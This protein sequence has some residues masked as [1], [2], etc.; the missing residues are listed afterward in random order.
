[1]STYQLVDEPARNAVIKVVGVGGG[2]G[3]AVSFMQ[4]TGI[5]GV[6]LVAVNTDLQALRA[7]GVRTTVQIGASLTRGLGAGSDPE[8][9]RQA[10]L[11][12]RDRLEEVV[13]GADMVFVTAG[14][15]GGTGTGA[16]AV[17]AQLAREA[18]ALVV[19]VVTR[20]FQLE[21][22]RRLEAAD[23][24]LEVLAQHCDSLIVVPNEKLFSVLGPDCTLD[25]AFETANGVLVGAVRGIADLIT[26]PGRM[27]LDFADVR[28]VMTQ[29]GT[30]V[31]GS[32][33][34]DGPGRAAEATRQAIE[35]PLLENVTLKGAR[36]VLVNVSCGTSPTLA[37]ISEIGRM[38]GE[39]AAED[40]VVK[41]GTHHDEELG[42]RLRV[43]VVATGLPGPRPPAGAAPRLVPEPNPAPPARPKPLGVRT[44]PEPPVFPGF[45][46]LASPAP[47]RRS[48]PPN[49]PVLEDEVRV[50]SSELPAFLR[51][52][53]D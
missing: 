20:P 12:D 11:E 52:Q 45:E 2:G 13:R 17:V 43:T 24:G 48:A 27:N 21:G 41:V 35:S 51:R 36:G 25:E 18:G 4:S 15:G 34:A 22:R 33:V 26:R 29:N 44:T 37:E 16:S 10:A 28:A 31:M 14:M 8:V 1:M 40:A 39:V 6:E 49:P 23:R 42:G 46:P 53:A 30:A 5:D 50:D 9:G 32:G 47:R 38:I 7:T 19:A 3:N